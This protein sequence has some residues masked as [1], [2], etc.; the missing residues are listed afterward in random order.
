MYTYTF[1][2]VAADE[3][4]TAYGWYNER[5]DMAADGFLIAIEETIQLIC[6]NPGR[7]RNTFNKLRE[8]SLKKYPYSIV[9]LADDVNKTILITSV[10]HHMRDPKKKYRK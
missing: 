8:V 2:L 1:D 9:Y 6:E 4:S 5:S 3:Y 10:Y 7:Y